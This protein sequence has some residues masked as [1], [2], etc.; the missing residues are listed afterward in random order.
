M[1]LMYSIHP[2]REILPRT[3]HLTSALE[4]LILRFHKQ[5]IFPLVRDVRECAFR[6][7]LAPAKLQSDNLQKITLQELAENLRHLRLDEERMKKKR[8]DFGDLP[9]PI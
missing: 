3:R 8:H 4:K 2:C 1:P 6:S 5:P 9:E 7:S